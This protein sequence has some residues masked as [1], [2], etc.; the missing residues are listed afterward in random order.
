[1]K[2]LRYKD[3]QFSLDAQVTELTGEQLY[4]WS[5]HLER[6]I[7]ISIPK[8]LSTGIDDKG[9]KLNSV[10]R[11]VMT[12]ALPKLEQQACRIKLELMRREA[13]LTEGFDYRLMLRD[14]S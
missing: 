2:Q 12:M 11:E 4:F 10:R 14:D 6:M 3:A 13:Q 1:M 5:A 9:R 7:T 8:A